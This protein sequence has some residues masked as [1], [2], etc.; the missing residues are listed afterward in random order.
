MASDMLHRLGSIYKANASAILSRLMAM[1]TEEIRALR[2]D[3]LPGVDQWTGT[4]LVNVLFAIMYQYRRQ[5]R[6]RCMLQLVEY[7]S[8]QYPFLIM[9]NESVRSPWRY[10]VEEFPELLQ[11]FIC[12]L[13]PTPDALTR[14]I[15]RYAPYS[16]E[17]L[18]RA[19]GDINALTNDGTTTLQR[20]LRSTL[21][22]IPHVKIAH[23]LQLRADPN[24][25][26]FPKALEYAVSSPMATQ[27]LLENGAKIYLEEHPHQSELS[28]KE[29]NVKSQKIIYNTNVSRGTLLLYHVFI[30]VIADKIKSFLRLPSPLAT[31]KR[32]RE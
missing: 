3:G 15:Q 22:D 26:S 25:G 16:I 20:L 1:S 4:D 2:I 10:A 32:K 9:D 21:H 7:V 27:L 29:I 13:K 8:C 23:L 14:E 6:D 31:L 17:V 18:A 12:V 5:S 19:G 28:V 30:P 11:H 24:L